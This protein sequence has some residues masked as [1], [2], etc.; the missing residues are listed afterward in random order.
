MNSLEVTYDFEEA[1]GGSLR[2]SGS[3]VRREGSTSSEGH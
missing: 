2:G 1:A 3:K